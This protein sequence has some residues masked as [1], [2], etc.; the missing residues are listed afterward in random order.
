MDSDIIAFFH[1]KL[2]HD[3]ASVLEDRVIIKSD[4]AKEACGFIEIEGDGIGGVRI[5][6]DRDH[7]A[8]ESRI[9]ANG[10][11]TG[12]ELPAS[13]FQ[14]GSIDLHCDL[15]FDEEFQDRI[16]QF[17]IIE[18]TI[19][20][21]HITQVA[22]N[23]IHVGVGVDIVKCLQTFQRVTK[24][25]TECLMLGP[26]LE[27]SGIVGV[28]IVAHMCGTDHKV[29]FP[30]VPQVLCEQNI[31]MRLKTELYAEIKVD[32]SSVLLAQTQK[33]FSVGLQIELKITARKIGSIEIRKIRIIMFGEAYL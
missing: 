5:G 25:G 32:P 30:I 20:F 17:G 3:R 19:I 24:I 18:I 8:A 6:S 12:I 2:F 11:D 9:S 23:I 29:K 26:S 15:M 14:S 33:F 16:D 4:I 31:Q 28:H 27:E 13:F 10:V 1:L 22:D 21:V 7:F